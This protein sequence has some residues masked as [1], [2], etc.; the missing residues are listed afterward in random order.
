MTRVRP[1]DSAT[2]ES[3]T[4]ASA[5]VSVV[6]DSARLDVDAELRGERRQQ[7]LHRV[8]QHE[9]RHPRAP[10]RE[11]QASEADRAPLVADGGF[12]HCHRY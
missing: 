5:S 7:P 1:H 3:G 9:R 10:H 8:H 12:G 11:T 2:A 6:A 4:I